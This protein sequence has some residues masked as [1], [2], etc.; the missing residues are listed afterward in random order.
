MSRACGTNR[1]KERY[2]RALRIR[3]EGK[4]TLGRTR[5]T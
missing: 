1:I 3:P 5:R 4:R 2:I